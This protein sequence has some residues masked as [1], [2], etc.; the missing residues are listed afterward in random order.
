M[1][2][3]KITI[4]RNEKIITGIHDHHIYDLFYKDVNIGYFAEYYLEK[5]MKSIE[6]IGFF[7][8][9]NYDFRMQN[10]DETGHI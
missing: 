4:K 10:I 8:G 1:R 2:N 9:K 5:A 3:D 7:D 6:E